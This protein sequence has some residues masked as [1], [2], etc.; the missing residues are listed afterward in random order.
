MNTPH[1]LRPRR[2]LLAALGGLAAGAVLAPRL[3]AQPAFSADP[4]TLGVASG[5]PEPTGVALWTRLAPQ[6]LAPGGGMPPEV[7]PVQ[8]EIA[9]DERFARVAASG[10]AHATPDWAHAVHVE[11]HGLAPE[12]WYW[13]R[14]HAGAATSPVGR[15]RTAPADEVLGERLRCCVASCQHYEQGWFTGYRHMISDAPDLIIHLGDYIYE[16]SWGEDHVRKHGSPEPVTLD[17]YRARFALYKSDPDLQAAHACCPWLVVWDDHELENDYADD[18]S[19]NDDQ[20][21]WFLERRAAAYQAY[22]EH[23]PLR[24]GMVPFGPHMRIHT[25]VRIGALASVFMLDDR[26]YRSY[27]PC[28]KP[29]RGGSNM[30]GDCAERLAPQA[31]ML[32]ARQ[33]RWLEAR[34]TESKARWN[35]LAQQTLMAPYDVLSGPGELFSSDS[36]GG[37]PAA[38]AR[39]LS[40]IA[41]RQ[42]SNPIVVG[43]DVHSFWVND[44]KT[45]HSRPESAVVATEF[46]TTS[47]TSQPIKE[48]HIRI[49]REE[50]P[51]IKF[52]TGEKRGYL[53]MDFSPRRLRA[54]LRA[55]SSVKT[56]T[57]ICETLAAFEVEDGHPGATAV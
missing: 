20:P 50:G 33:E 6:P 32:G 25:D 41:A 12:R 22:Y 13:Y 42:P 46:V 9:L 29:G 7:V 10:T 15:T 57:S 31:T 52:A 16:S 38:R 18:R 45:D 36:W 43:G 2:H 54:E 11:V 27:Q 49:A 21:A 53:R 39:L 26:Q 28:P 5:Y 34:L 30:I 37:Y 19:E 4:F 56:E 40:F 47:V 35:L 51:H 44:L 1:I 3:R 17:D 24:R 55:L 8:W 14:F 48:E 23:M